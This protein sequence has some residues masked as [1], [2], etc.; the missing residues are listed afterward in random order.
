ME[1]VG[2]GDLSG[3][4]VHRFPMISAGME[5]EEFDNFV[6]QVVGRENGTY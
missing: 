2:R 1:L 5:Q 4:W 3:P 6:E